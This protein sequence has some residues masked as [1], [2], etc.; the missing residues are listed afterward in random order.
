MNE[1]AK[2]RF[3]I[4]GSFECWDGPDRVRIG[5]PVHER[6]LVA[7]LLEPGR[8]LPVYRL[9]EAVWDENAP[10]TAAHQ[11]RKAVAELRQRI[12]DGRTLIVT[13]GPGYRAAVAPDQSDLSPF[14]EGLRQAREAVAA[15]RSAD[16][17]E[18]LREALTLWR[19]PVLSDSGGSVIAAASVA[20]EE[21]R[22]TAVEQLFTM[23]LAAGES[24]E[25]VGELREF[26]GAQTLRETLRGQL[27]LALFRSGRQ[28]E[29][30]EEY[31]KVRELLAAELGIDPGDRLQELHQGILRNSPDLAIPIPAGGS[32]ALPPLLNETR[33]T[34]PYDLRDFTGREE[35]MSRLLGFVEESERSGPLIVAI[36]GMGGSGKTSLAVRAAHQLADRYPDAQLYLDLRGFT[37]GEQPLSSATAAVT[38]LR[39]LGTPGEW[40]PDD[41]EGRTALWRKTTTRYRMILLLDN[42][43]DEAQVRPLLASSVG[44]L[45]LVTSRSLLVDLDATHCVSLGT[46]LPR[47][48]VALVSRVLEDRRAKAEPEAVA[49]LAELCGHLPLA[50]R[51]ASAR[52]R[53]RPRW[54][55]RYLVE[56][57]AGRRAAAGGAERRRAQRRG[58]PPAL[59]RG[60]RR[61]EPAGVPA[62]GAAPGFRTGRVRGRR[63]A[64][65]GDPRGRGDTGAPPRHA[66]GAA[67]R[68]RPVRLSRSGAQFRAQ[69][70]AVGG[71]R[72]R[73]AG[74]ARLTRHRRRP[75]ARYTV[76]FVQ[77]EMG[78]ACGAVKDVHA[79]AR[80][81]ASRAGCTGHVTEQDGLRLLKGR[82]SGIYDAQSNDSKN[83]GLFL[84]R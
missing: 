74:G 84:C 57:A 62:A 24:S 30:L 2:V 38:L 22:L 10:A 18:S 79:I 20:L 40:I 71:A 68:G 59:L 36:D 54:T 31:E 80:V 60:S 77:P 83:T 5:G 66:L 6:V 26:I 53:K 15:G 51:I 67:A 33:S 78:P 55:V 45:I 47:D 28:G 58:H 12:P 49:E 70:V 44:T 1:D 21:R 27:M 39:M 4:L 3:R 64:R 63:A 48:S 81:F 56:P 43:V 41:A 75:Q 82:Q 7:L 25:L 9:V 19:G 14:I 69:P 23:R 65:Q 73:G 13:D 34:L 17:A 46:M 37:A 16:A 35:E 76:S 61:G 72:P 11:V 42:V 50:L 52:L 29:A 32:A 8:V